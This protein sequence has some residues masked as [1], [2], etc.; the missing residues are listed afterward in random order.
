MK[1]TLLAAGLMASTAVSAD[2]FVDSEFALDRP[3]PEAKPEVQ[4][5][6]VEAYQRTRYNREFIFAGAWTNLEG[7]THLSSE[8][9]GAMAP[10]WDRDFEIDLSARFEH[11]IPLLPNVKVSYYSFDDES[12][13]GMDNVVPGYNY[14]SNEADVYELSAYYRV[15]NGEWFRFDLGAS[16]RSFEGRFNWNDGHRWDHGSYSEQ[17]VAP[18]VASYFYVPHTNVNLYL[19]YN[20]IGGDSSYSDFSAGVAYRMNPD[21]AFRITL[22]GGYRAIEAELT[23]MSGYVGAELDSL[24][25]DFN[26]MFAGLQL[27]F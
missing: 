13:Y 12:G 22:F 18:Y 8:L 3:A 10:N 27:A 21:S 26:G 14:L 9:G 16:F 23:D 1:Y 4:E 17:F 6:E 20:G 2:A 24:E 15:F 19:E 5:P 25:Y 7:D 11:D